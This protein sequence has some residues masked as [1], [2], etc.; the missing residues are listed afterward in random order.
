MAISSGS[1]PSGPRW[2]RI[3]RTVGYGVILAV[4]AVVWLGGMQR[5]AAESASA[6]QVLLD[7]RHHPIRAGFYSTFSD[8]QR[9]I[10]VQKRACR[11]V[12]IRDEPEQRGLLDKSTAQALVSL[13]ACSLLDGLPPDSQARQGVI[14]TKLWRLLLPQTPPPSVAE[15]VSAM[16]LSFEATDFSDP[17]EWNFCQDNAEVGSARL[18]AARAGRCI[19]SSD[20]CSMLT[21]GPRGATAGQ[22][23]EIQYVLWRIWQRRPSDIITVFGAESVNVQRFVRL[24]GPPHDHCDGGSLLEHFMCAVWTNDDRRRQ[25]EQG[26]LDLSRL[27]ATRKDYNELYAEFLFDGEKLANYERLWLELG[28]LPSEPLTSAAH[29]CARRNSWLNWQPACGSSHR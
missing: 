25:W 29:R 20:S 14:T 17:P 11:T 1:G 16:T 27:E 24:Q 26:L 13:F 15:R 6:D 5:F 8:L 12:R 2:C 18:T 9:E 28:L 22:G 23:R 3:G 19:N 7:P 10:Y 21:W 4:G